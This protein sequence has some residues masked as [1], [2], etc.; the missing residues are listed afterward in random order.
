[1]IQVALE[2]VQSVL[3]LF[4]DD[5]IGTQGPYG[6]LCAVLVKVHLSPCT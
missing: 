3:A 4:S 1:M 2:A 5:D 6:E